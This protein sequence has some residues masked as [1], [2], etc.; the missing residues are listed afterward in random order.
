MAEPSTDRRG[1]PSWSPV[2][3]S[4][5]R[6]KWVRGRGDDLHFRAHTTLR[7][8][9]L[10]VVARLVVLDRIEDGVRGC[11]RGGWHGSPGVRWRRWPMQTRCCACNGRHGSGDNAA[12]RQPGPI[13]VW[14][15]TCPFAGFDAAAI[16][17]LPAGR[18][19]LPRPRTASNDKR[20]RAGRVG[21]S[22]SVRT[23]VS[24]Y[25][26]RERRPRPASVRGIAPCTAVGPVCEN[27]IH[28]GGE[29]MAGGR[30]SIRKRVV[31]KK[32]L[33]GFAMLLMAGGEPLPDVLNRLESAV[34]GR[35]ED[36]IFTD[37]I[38]RHAMVRAPAAPSKPAR[39]GLLRVGHP[40]GR[41]VVVTD[42]VR[43]AA[44]ADRAP[45]NPRS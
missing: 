7:A 5:N 10:G 19:S 41:R 33:Q 14:R 35:V 3:W 2:R 20:I 11:R 17:R 22:P 21:G 36:D 32:A 40:P 13:V 42:S 37:E 8:V 28:C 4:G 9:F 38:G 39:P 16:G 31:V 24:T 23:T 6:H 27:L 34:D 15:R 12:Q 29:I 26:G 43:T 25:C 1:R 45:H 18:A 30:A 44:G